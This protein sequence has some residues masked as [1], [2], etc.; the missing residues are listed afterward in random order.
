MKE[1]KTWCVIMGCLLVSACAGAREV[2]IDPGAEDPIPVS[3]A[4]ATVVPT[5]GNNVRG[6]VR[7][8]GAASGVDVVTTLEGLPGG[9]HAYH[10]HVYGDCSAPDATSA[11]PHFHFHGSSL[12]TK[13]K[14]ITGNLGELTGDGAGRAS[15]RARIEAASLQ[16]EYSIIGRAVVVHA[17]GNNPEITPD[18]GAGARIACGVIGV[19]NPSEAGTSAHPTHR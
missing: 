8:R 17:Q 1:L 16:G 10:V 13:E 4:I 12:N 18:G 3:E 7:F 14:I 15:H 11:G 9:V 5:E 19:A 2:L 6:T